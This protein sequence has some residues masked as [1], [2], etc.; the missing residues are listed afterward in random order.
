MGPPSPYLAPLCLALCWSPLGS[1]GTTAPLFPE[2]ESADKVTSDSWAGEPDLRAPRTQW[3]QG[4]PHAPDM[5]DFSQ[6]PDASACREQGSKIQ[7]LFK[8][9]FS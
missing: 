3:R 6:P 5:G 8:K 7:T 9:S 2:E 4:H 1:R